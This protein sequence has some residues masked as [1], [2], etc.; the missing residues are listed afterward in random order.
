MIVR[1][2]LEV[3]SVGFLRCHRLMKL[4][5]LEKDCSD[6]LAVEDATRED[7]GVGAAGGDADSGEK[8]SRELRLRKI[9]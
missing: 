9:R 8:D 6:L 1:P 4:P 2:S 7:F 5:G 3:A